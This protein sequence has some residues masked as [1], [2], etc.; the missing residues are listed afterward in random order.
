MHAGRN[1][2]VVLLAASLASL[3]AAS[4]LG[5]TTTAPT[6]LGTVGQRAIALRTLEGQRLTVLN[7]GR[8]T[9]LVRDRSARENFH[10]VGPGIN[11]RTTIRFVGSRS[12][13]VRLAAGTYRYR[14][15]AHP[16]RLRGTVRVR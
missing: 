2:V 5:A 1:A 3:A 10:L 4:T 13:T 11:R 9:I 6:V 7:P 16:A 14:S 15:D 8:Y 12:W